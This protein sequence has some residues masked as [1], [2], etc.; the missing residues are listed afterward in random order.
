M[1]NDTQNEQK[2]QPQENVQKRPVM[3]HIPGPPITNEMIKI[4]MDN[5]MSSQILN[6][7]NVWYE[8]TYLRHVMMKIL[9]KN[10]DVN[11][12]MCPEDFGEARTE[13]QK[14]L[15]EKFPNYGLNFANDPAVPHN[16]VPEEPKQA[17]VSAD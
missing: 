8:V 15:L 4:I 16:F 6:T 3:E 7:V 9:E 1:T 17:E 10:P 12:N 13:A 5:V 11:K 14:Q 2:E